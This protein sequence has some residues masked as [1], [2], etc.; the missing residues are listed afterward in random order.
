MNTLDKIK[1][2]QLYLMVLPFQWL[3][4]HY[5]S[6]YIGNSSK[7]GETMSMIWNL[8]RNKIDIFC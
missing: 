3:K 2:N 4:L 8:K 6:Q 7:F 1:F 5:I